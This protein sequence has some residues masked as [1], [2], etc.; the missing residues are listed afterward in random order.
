MTLKISGKI[1][2]NTLSK[3]LVASS[4][5][6]SMLALAPLAAFA[7][8]TTIDGNASITAMPVTASASMSGS[9]S[10]KVAAAITKSISRADQ[11]LTRRI[12][13]LNSASTR[14]GDMKNLSASEKT[15]LQAS[16]STEIGNL[17]GL[18]A[19]IDA[20]TDATV[21][22]TDV[23][24]ITNDYRVYMLVLPQGR[25]AAATDRVGTIV[26]EMQQLGTKLQARI[27]TAQTAGKN[28]T[29]AQSA[30]TDMQAKLTDANT[31]AQAALSETQSLQPDQGNA[32]VQASNTAA[33]KDALSKLKTAQSDLKAARADIKTIMD[34]VKGTGGASVNASS[35]TSVTAQ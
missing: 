2:Q 25:I 20:D 7:Q 31:Q 10:T 11:E 13:N 3:T 14:D 9:A 34:A 32:T 12:S 22:K 1:S 16:I 5:I 21:L 15:S 18:K 17:T 35:T 33:I 26:S 24:S 4:V 8:T 6:G 29:A 28:V 23:K 30:Y 19:K 27:T